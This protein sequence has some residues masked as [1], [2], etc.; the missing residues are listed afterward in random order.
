MTNT[1]VIDQLVTLYVQQ[2]VFAQQ[3]K[4]VA[5]AAK[6]AGLDHK[7]LVAIA[8]AKAKDKLEDLKERTDA[9]QAV[10]NQV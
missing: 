4:E 2:D 7:A 3:A 1:E 6:E 5:D 8:K 10:L 9:L